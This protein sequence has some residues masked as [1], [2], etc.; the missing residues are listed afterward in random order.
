MN[1]IDITDS[2]VNRE[3]AKE[4]S[5]RLKGS[6]KILVESFKLVPQNFAKVD[7]YPMWP[8]KSWMIYATAF[9]GAQWEQDIFGAAFFGFSHV[10]A[11]Y[12]T[13]VIQFGSFLIDS[14]ILKLLQVYVGLTF[15]RCILHIFSEE[16]FSQFEQLFPI[17]I[18][19]FNYL[20]NQI[21]N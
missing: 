19:I 3:K 21:Y 12:R 8:K 1:P 7:H 11:S 9:W 4:F 18:D 10:G 5:C 6:L 15:T 16:R 14:F 2:Y 20:I 13:Q 17:L